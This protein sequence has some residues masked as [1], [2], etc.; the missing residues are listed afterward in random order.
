LDSDQGLAAVARELAR[1]A[2]FFGLGDGNGYYFERFLL[3]MRLLATSGIE[4]GGE[5]VDWPRLETP[6][7]GACSAK[8][9]WNPM[10]RRIHGESS[11]SGPAFRHDV[12]THPGA[13]I[14]S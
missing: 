6:R 7:F 14:R 8:G 13:E 4:L 2:V 10:R 11:S 5:R 1:G 12:A 9:D 3:T